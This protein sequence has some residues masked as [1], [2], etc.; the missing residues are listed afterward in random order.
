MSVVNRE[1]V[2]QS[3]LIVYRWCIGRDCREC[4]LMGE[5]GDCMIRTPE[6]WNLEERLRNR[7]VN[8]NEQ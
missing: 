6:A 8:K 5:L 7:G 2:V 4:P 3:A 1:D